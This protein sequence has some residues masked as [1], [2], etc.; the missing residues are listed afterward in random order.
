VKEPSHNWY[1]TGL[2]N[3]RPRGCVGSN[4]TGSVNESTTVVL[5]TRKE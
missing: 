5:K 1:C 2:E 3:R 4:P